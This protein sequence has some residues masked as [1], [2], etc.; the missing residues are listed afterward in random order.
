MGHHLCQIQVA[1]GQ[2][3][4]CEQWLCPSNILYD[5]VGQSFLG[6][7]DGIQNFLKLNA[8]ESKDVSL[9]FQSEIIA[10]VLELGD[11]GF[12]EVVVWAEPD[13]VITI[14]EYHQL[15]FL[16]NEEAGI[17]LRCLKSKLGHALAKV[18]IEELGGIHLS[19]DAFV[20]FKHN[21]LTFKSNWFVVLGKLHVEGLVRRLGTL[22]EGQGKV[23]LPRFPSLGGSQNQS[24]S[25]S[26]EPNQRTVGSSIIILQ[27][28]TTAPS[29]LEFVEL[30][31]R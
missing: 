30:P 20:H 17:S 21:I 25:N 2:L 14:V 31:I 27:V 9:W 5:L 24:S 12:N 4:L 13:L 26:R 3:E 22:A 19:I 23:D 16:M 8:Q 6:Q 29:A 7:L 28:T 10:K 15:E 11:I 18:L 1:P